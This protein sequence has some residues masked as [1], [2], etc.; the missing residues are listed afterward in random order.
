MPQIK[1]MA[2]R[3]KINFGSRKKV[4]DIY[5][6][7]KA[8]TSSYKW[9]LQPELIHEERKRRGLHEVFLEIFPIKDFSGNLMLEYKGY[10]LG[11]PRCKKCPGKAVGEEC[12]FEN[13][14]YDERNCEIA[15][16]GDV[17]FR[18]K[19]SEQETKKKSLTYAVRLELVVELINKSTG[20]IKRQTL[21]LCDLPIMTSRGTFIYNGTERVI[22]SQLHRSPGA[23]FEYDKA[24]KSYTAKIIPYRGAWIE[25]EL[26]VIKDLIHVRLDRKRKIP[27]TTFM[28]ALGFRHEEIKEMF[29][30]HPYIMKTFEIDKAEDYK[31]ALKE[32]FHKLRPGEPFAADNAIQLLRNLYFDRR[33]YDFSTVGRY[34]LNRKIRLKDRIIKK[35]VAENITDKDG[36]IVVKEG[37]V[38]SADAAEIIETLNLQSIKVRNN[39][40]DIVNTK[41]EKDIE[42]IYLNDFISFASDILAGKDKVLYKKGTVITEEIVDKLE[43]QKITKADIYRK[44]V[45][46][47]DK[48]LLELRHILN[49]ID[50]NV[51]EDSIEIEKYLLGRTVAKDYEFDYEGKHIVIKPGDEITIGRAEALINSG[52]DQIEVTKGRVLSETDITAMVRYLIDLSG[53]IGHLDDIDHLGNRRVRRCG[54]MLQN[55]FRISLTKMER[56]I[57]E[58][59]TLQDN[60]G[61]TAQN[62]INNRPIKA[63]LDDFYGT[64]QLSQFMDQTNPIAELTNKRRISALGPGGVKRERAGYEVR[65]VHPTHFGK[66]CPIETPEG[67]NAGLIASLAVYTRVNRFGFLE[68]PYRV[69]RNNKISDDIIYMD[70][71]EEDDFVIVPPD[72]EVNKDETF[73]NAL[74]PVKVHS[75]IGHEFSMVDGSLADYCMVSPMQMISV[76]ASLIPFLEHDD[77]NRALMGTNMQRQAVPL[78]NTEVPFVGTGIERRVAIDSGTG[79]V[80]EYD[81]IVETVAGDYIL[82]RRTDKTEVVNLGSPV[83][84][85]VVRERKIAS[86]AKVGKKVIAKKDTVM[87]S[88]LVDKLKKEGVEEVEMYY[89]KKYFVNKFQ[90]SNQSTCL[91]QRPIVREGDVLKA[92]DPIADGAATASSEVALGRNMLVAFMP[93]EGYNYEDAIIISERLVKD[94][95]LTS[96]HIEEYEVETRDT[97]LGPEEITRDIPNVGQEALRNLDEQ[98]I[99]RVGAEVESGDILVGKVTPKGETDLTV[100]DKLLRAIF[101]EK[102][103]DVRNTSYTVPHG[104]SGTVIDVNVFSRDNNDEL[105]H[106][107]NT[108]VRT[109]IAQKRKI[110]VGDKMAGR[111]G[112]KG[113]IARIL[114]EDDMPFMEDGTPVDI[115][116]NPLGVPSRMNLGQVL[117]AHLGYIGYVFNVYNE[118][119]VFDGINEKDLFRL[120]V[121]TNLVKN[122]YAP[123]YNTDNENFANLRIER[124]LV[125]D[126]REILDI[127]IE[128]G[129]Y[130]AF[131]FIMKKYKGKITNIQNNITVAELN[132]T[133]DSKVSKAFETNKIGSLFTSVEEYYNDDAALEPMWTISRENMTNTKKDLKQLVNNFKVQTDKEIILESLKNADL[134]E[135]ETGKMFLYDGRN[136]KKFENPVLVGNVY[137][138][139]LHHLVDDKIH[140]RATGPYS[141]VT[142][143]PLGGKAQFG[144]QRFGEMEVWALEAYGAAHILQEMLTVKSDDVEGR[145]QVYETIIK[146]GNTIKASVP[147]S[148]KVLVS[149]LQSLC[150][151]VELIK[152]DELSSVTNDTE[153]TDSLENT[154]TIA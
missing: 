87:T 145:V 48:S 54:E 137:M 69:V 85:K 70:A 147:E 106:D 139:K 23:Y 118:T 78:L 31:D 4:L 111:H 120:L 39:D 128:K 117:E 12:R 24:K 113:V 15:T 122:G 104:E 53:G 62:F 96:M 10:N 47:I 95:V 32:I 138:L 94:D 99:I 92:G 127:A 90:R 63:M 142:Q 64:S 108:L 13:C 98:G 20:E 3:T 40:G 22:V 136:G 71:Y 114:S 74:V 59:M 56:E 107:I 140:A 18:I 89:Y 65:D 30:E 7:I 102:A 14:T 55:Q 26:D 73:H 60:Q 75:E 135:N 52:L 150:L 6:L 146:G 25:F 35:T 37:E 1:E 101:G 133:D 116:L 44:N 88:S 132:T 154:S 46:Y 153:G 125:E 103:R 49:D 67:P 28:K 68:T 149:E 121:M 57:K 123:L 42:I 50:Q 8:Q 9:F 17:P 5:E 110:I 33:R 38:I 151:K 82:I 61:V 77:A 45:L 105:P 86:D 115:V 124:I 126:R 2:G 51:I 119:P 97:K 80:T 21:Y 66:L 16:V 11:L 112:N 91:N 100:E 43:E 19:N 79:I 27:V 129:V 109:Y 131:A 84:G 143:Q 41:V 93:W 83:A 141:L 58:K 148:F 144:G 72:V 134:F 76:A 130:H 81:G 29:N 34:K 36:N 152:D